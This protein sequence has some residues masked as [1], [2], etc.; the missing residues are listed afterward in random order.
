MTFDEEAKNL[1]QKKEEQN[2]RGPALI[3]K[4]TELEERKRVPQVGIG[5]ADR[6][7]KGYLAPQIVM[8][9]S[10]DIKYMA[11]NPSDIADDWNRLVDTRVERGLIYLKKNETTFEIAANMIGDTL[12]DLNGE[13]SKI[14]RPLFDELAGNWLFVDLWHKWLELRQR[15][16]KEIQKIEDEE[17]PLQ[18]QLNKI[19][20]EIAKSEAA[21]KAMRSD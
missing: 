17:K 8:A 7:A 16:E 13:D 18:E 15:F 11:R 10:K 19:S 5:L 2:K 20:L 14:I 3:S 6:F 1:K 12:R 9:A 21:I 4:L